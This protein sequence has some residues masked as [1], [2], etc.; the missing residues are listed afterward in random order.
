MNCNDEARVAQGVPSANAGVGEGKTLGNGSAKA[1]APPRTLDAG[2]RGARRGT[3][4][5]RAPKGDLENSVR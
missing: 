3:V 5:D 4:E 2:P 1:G